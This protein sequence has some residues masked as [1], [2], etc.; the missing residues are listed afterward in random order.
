M[1]NQ[2]HCHIK[3][4]LS[5][6]FYVSHANSILYENF[7]DYFHALKH[8]KHYYYFRICLQREYICIESCIQ[9]GYISGKKLL[10]GCSIVILGNTH[11]L[12]FPIFC[13]PY[14]WTCKLEF[15]LL[16]YW[17]DT[18]GLVR[19]GKNKGIQLKGGNGV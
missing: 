3:K 18:E 16:F 8:L 17:L 10:V 2:Y 19:M 9:C 4:N 1:I 5:E 12:L 6:Y 15:S 7:S 13:D 11:I 14:T